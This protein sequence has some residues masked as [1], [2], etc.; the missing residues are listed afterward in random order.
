MGLGDWPR[1][2]TPLRP[3]L[4]EH[5]LDLTNM[6][7][8][9]TLHTWSFDSCFVDQRFDRATTIAPESMGLLTS[10]WCVP[11]HSDRSVEA[12]RSTPCILCNSETDP[13]VLIEQWALLLLRCAMLRIGLAFCQLCRQLS[14]LGL[15]PQQI[16]VGF[17]DALL[18]TFDE[19][20]ARVQSPHWGNVQSFHVTIST[21]PHLQSRVPIAASSAVTLVRAASVTTC[22]LLIGEKRCGSLLGVV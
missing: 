15:K 19:L 12:R 2:R 20:V 7:N 1:P 13:S 4:A 21:L 9:T 16:R 11:I 6:Q 3:H 18:G 17:G 8:S 10:P 5:L 14:A 22:E